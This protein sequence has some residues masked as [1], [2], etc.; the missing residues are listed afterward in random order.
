MALR[1]PAVS[2]QKLS[3]LC[4]I[5]KGGFRGEIET[6]GA[7]WRAEEPGCSLWDGTLVPGVCGSRRSEC[8]VLG[9]EHHTECDGY[10]GGQRSSRGA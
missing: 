8:N 6:D 10:L 3:R 9:S 5:Q 2:I 1:P 7:V 4:I